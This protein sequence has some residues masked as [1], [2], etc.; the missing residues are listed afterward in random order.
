MDWLSPHYAILDCHA[1]TVTLVMRGVPRVKWR[2]TLDHTPNRVISSLKAQRMVEKGCDT[3]LAYMRDVR[4]DTPS[5]DSVP[6][7]WDFPNVFP[8][9]LP[10]MLTNRDI[11]FSIDLLLVTQPISIPLYHMA[12]SELK[13]LKDQLQELLDKG[14]IRPSKSPWGAPV[15][16]VKK[17]D[18]S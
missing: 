3:Y 5:V 4:I 14:F 15:L 2:G 17:T 16:F 10:G 12:P 7:V 1:K 18:G 6:V 9:D 11:D 8:N 13:E